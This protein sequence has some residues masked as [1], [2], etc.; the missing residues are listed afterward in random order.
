ME[1]VPG[2]HKN[3][4]GQNRL[5]IPFEQNQHPS[6]WCSK[7]VNQTLEKMLMGNKDQ[8]KATPKEHQK[9][10]TRSHETA[11]VFLQYKGSLTH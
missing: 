8:F 9:S 3:T 10:E 5:Q 7:I 4:G 1:F 11:T 6:E 2:G